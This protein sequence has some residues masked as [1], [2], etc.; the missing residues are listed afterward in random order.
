MLSGATS[1]VAGFRYDV[2]SK[3]RAW[4]G[5]T[6]SAGPSNPFGTVNTDGRQLSLFATYVPG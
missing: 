1:E 3:A 6:Y 5:N 4:N 2:V